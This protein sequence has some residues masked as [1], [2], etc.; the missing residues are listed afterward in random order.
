MEGKKERKKDAEGD[1]VR[2][3]E[4]DQQADGVRVSTVLFKLH[5]RIIMMNSNV[6]SEGY[7]GPPD[8]SL[9]S[10][11][12]PPCASGCVLEWVSV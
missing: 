9:F 5:W 1:R 12:R 6:I 10:L 2:R 4:R 8:H 7:G 11:Q 3:T